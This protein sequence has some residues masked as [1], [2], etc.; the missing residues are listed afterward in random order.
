MPEPLPQKLI[1]ESQTFTLLQHLFRSFVVEGDYDTEQLTKVKIKDFFL[2]VQSKVQHITEQP[3]SA[4]WLEQCKQALFPNRDELQEAHQFT[5]DTYDDVVKLVRDPFAL[6]GVMHSWWPLLV[7]KGPQRVPIKAISLNCG[8]QFYDEKV[9]SI[10]MPTTSEMQGQP[11][12][13]GLMVS[14]FRAQLNS[15]VAMLLN[16]GSDG[17]YNHIANAQPNS[18]THLD[19]NWDGNPGGLGF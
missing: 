8:I 16:H 10:P 11:I 4:L 9:A 13:A 3:G 17:L 7:L 18:Q 1:A 5:R 19:S 6:C 15:F 2:W 12:T 14:L